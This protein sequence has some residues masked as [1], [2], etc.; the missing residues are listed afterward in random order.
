[1]SEIQGHWSKRWQPLV[2]AFAQNMAESGEE[3]AALAV[4]RAGAPIVSI[5]A[6]EA[7]AG[8]PWEERTQVNLFSASKGIVALAVLQM[9]DEGKLTLD[10]PVADYWPG[11][12]SAGKASITVRDLLCHRS[13]L[14]ALKERVGEKDIFDWETMVRRV[15]AAEPWWEPGEKQGYSPFLFGWAL[16]ELVRRVAGADRFSECVRERIARPLGLS[17]GFG[18]GPGDVRVAQSR[19]LKRPL[20][21]ASN[22]ADSQSLGRIMK[23]DP[24]GVTN[25]AFSNPMTLLTASNSEDWRTA[26]IPAA[27]GHSSALDLA[28]LYGALANGGAA[29]NGQSLLSEAALSR[30]SE[31]LTFEEDQVLGLPLR[32]GHGFMLSQKRA[33]CRFGRGRGAFGHPGA[34]GCLGFADPDYGIGF[35]YVTGRMGQSLLIDPRPQRLIDALYDL[36]GDAP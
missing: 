5:W 12:G 7:E 13:G 30:C 14:S 33:D 8:R 36:L 25:K 3:A 21:G 27:N 10:C 34:G 24:R 22:G 35:G 28:T 17:L 31:E 15:E 23:A 32:F 9:V 29:L 16:G 4:F 18:A 26:E 6:G 19:P 20:G 2:D 1:M 11:F